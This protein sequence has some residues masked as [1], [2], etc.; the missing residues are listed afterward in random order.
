MS[1]TLDN[2]STPSI[3]AA[4]GGG[5]GGGYDE[6]KTDYVALNQFFWGKEVAKHAASRAK[7]RFLASMEKAAD[8]D[9]MAHPP[10]LAELCAFADPLYNPRYIYQGFLMM[11]H[12][13]LFM[14]RSPSYSSDPRHDCV[15]IYYD[16]E[17]GGALLDYTPQTDCPGMGVT[18]SMYTLP[19]AAT[20]RDIVRTFCGANCEIGYTC[21]WKGEDKPR[22]ELLATTMGS[23]SPEYVPRP[24]EIHVHAT[25]TSPLSAT[26]GQIVNGVV[27]N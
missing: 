26:R 17:T 12:M 11:I 5:G 19:G 20:M 9:A 18:H 14:F 15:S 21:A 4:C 16:K 7:P 8:A 13:D 25:K 2:K 6:D 3:P 24:F 10:V 22:I 23:M 27:V 1:V